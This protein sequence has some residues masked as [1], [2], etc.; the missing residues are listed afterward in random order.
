MMEMVTRVRVPS[1]EA[2]YITIEAMVHRLASSK[3][4][5]PVQFYR[6]QE[7]QKRQASVDSQW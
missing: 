6:D 5:N 1:W 2:A 7:K 4:A 3:H